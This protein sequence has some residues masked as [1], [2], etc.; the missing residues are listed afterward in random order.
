M[1]NIFLVLLVALIC[2]G[3]AIP[4]QA[5]QALFV[6]GLP[7]SVSDPI[8]RGG[9]YYVP[10]RPLAA[11]LGYTAVWNERTRR[12]TL[13][14]ADSELIL[15]ESVSVSYRG[16]TSTL[17]RAPMMRGGVF[18]VPVRAL[19]EF[20]GARVDYV[21]SSDA[22]FAY[23]GA[24]DSVREVRTAAGLHA[25]LSRLAGD[26]MLTV[27]NTGRFGMD[28]IAVVAE[29]GSGRLG[30]VSWV[31]AETLAPIS[32]L[33][34]GREYKTRLVFPEWAFGQ[35]YVEVHWVDS[36]RFRGVMPPQSEVA[37]SIP[38]SFRP[39]DKAAGG[40]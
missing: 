9:A 28:L 37:M 22:V 32:R 7:I 31:D 33:I 14:N 20:L 16:R 12:V 24:T 5:L 8:L 34:S 6:D 10:V 17:R 39:A 15:T 2:L 3:Q 30:L 36:A 18:Y 23:T 21:A 29:P 11:A 4:A 35:S 40:R 26:T 19:L 38:I 25:M 13:T 27:S 1:K